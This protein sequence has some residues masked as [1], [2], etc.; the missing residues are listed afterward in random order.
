MYNDTYL[1]KKLP[2]ILLS[3]VFSVFL[4]ST[5]LTAQTTLGVTGLL[6]SPSA[7]MSEDGTVKIGGNF[8]NTNMTPNTWNYNTFNYFV[9]ITFLPFFEVALTNTAFKLGGSENFNNVDRAISVRLRVLKEHKYL[10]SVVVGS[11]DLL[12]SNR[13]NYFS[14]TKGNKYFGMNYVAASKHVIFNENK[15]GFHAAYNILS[16]K[17]QTLDNPISGGITFT[18]SFARDLAVIAEYDTRDFNLGG[19]YLLFKTFYIQA[20]VQEFKYLS[21]GGH[22]I[23]SLL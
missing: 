11:N 5:E 9:N 18:P 21:F 14:P 4:F 7:T 12:T 2:A 20:F 23:I 16:S 15:L 10:P 17:K 13:E 8:L 1:L 22:F 6:N 3:V 19:S